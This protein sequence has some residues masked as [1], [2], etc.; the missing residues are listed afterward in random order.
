MTPRQKRIQRSAMEKAAAA[1]RKSYLGRF[2]P[3]TCIQSAWVKSLL[4]VWGECY[5]GRTS[6]VAMLGGY[7]FWSCLKAEE[8]SDK[9]AKHITDTL[10]GLH[11]IGYRGEALQKMAMGILW[12]QKSLAEMMNGTVFEDDC[13]FV[14]RCIL[15]ALSS[16]DPV[17]VV[18]ISFYA[19]HK[20]IS[21]I[22]NLLQ[23]VAPWLTRK[24]AEDRVRWCLTHFNAA[25]F[26]VMKSALKEECGKK[27]ENE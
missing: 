26:L 23:S 22:A 20:R 9:Q 12:P 2:T 27:L 11:K 24:Q 1:P 16:H 21:D 15:N 17:Y 25:V 19:R 8:W 7:R 6:E 14:E 13:N 18:G 5:G 10:R 4:S 3:L